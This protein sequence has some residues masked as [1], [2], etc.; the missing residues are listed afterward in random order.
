M[1]TGWAIKRNTI[2]LGSFEWVLFK[3]EI[4]YL[5][6][7]LR[8]NQVHTNAIARRKK[9][10]LLNKELFSGSSTDIGGIFLELWCPNHKHICVV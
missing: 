1:I 8:K 6:N 5:D 2:L 3:Y 7:L 4:L 9:W 10:T